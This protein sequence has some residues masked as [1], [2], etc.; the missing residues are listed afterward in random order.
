MFVYFLPRWANLLKSKGSD[1]EI[2]NFHHPFLQAWGMCLGEMTC[3]LVFYTVRYFKRRRVARQGED[4]EE[5]ALISGNTAE[6]DPWLQN[7]R[8]S[9]LVFLP[10]AIC[11]MT[12][13][14][15]MFIGLILTNASS[16]QMLR[17][18]KS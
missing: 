17:G 6:G 9:L 2:R 8:F 7:R 11:H 14:S 12:G 10:S 4:N 5:S 16:F 15:V 18:K 3:L 13:R 1:G